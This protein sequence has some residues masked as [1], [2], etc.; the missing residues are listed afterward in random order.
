MAKLWEE[1]SQAEKIEDLR[2][3]IKAIMASVNQMGRVAT[4][5]EGGISEIAGRAHDLGSRVAKLEET[6]G[7]RGA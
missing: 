7:K 3:D 1:M 5:L 6:L 2:R 4:A